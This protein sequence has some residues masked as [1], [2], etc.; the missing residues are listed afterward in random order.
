MEPKTEPCR[1]RIDRGTLKSA[2]AAPKPTGCGGLLPQPVTGYTQ[3]R[4]DKALKFRV[5]RAEIAFN[6]VERSA[7]GSGSAGR[8]FDEGEATDLPS[9]GLD[10]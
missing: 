9:I 1:D 7:P 3:K 6:G 10:G 4:L 2:T 5:T 8:G